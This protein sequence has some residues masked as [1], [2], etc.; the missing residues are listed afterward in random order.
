MDAVAAGLAELDGEGQL[1]W[2]CFARLEWMRA[3]ALKRRA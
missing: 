1:Y 2:E 3:D